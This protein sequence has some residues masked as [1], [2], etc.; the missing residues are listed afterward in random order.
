MFESRSWP[1]GFRASFG[2]VTRSRPV[3]LGDKAR[4]WRTGREV[5][6]VGRTCPSVA[7]RGAG[8]LSESCRTSETLA[9]AV[10]LSQNRIQPEIYSHSIMSRPRVTGRSDLLQSSLELLQELIARIPLR[11]KSSVL[12]KTQ[13]DTPPEMYSRTTAILE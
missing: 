8:N 12:K 6:D 9:T 10:N 4:R 5:F 7:F 3:V 11:L 13:T 2:P 1:E